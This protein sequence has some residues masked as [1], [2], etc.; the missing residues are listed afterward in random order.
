MAVGS[1]SNRDA[2]D[3]AHSKIITN[4][5]KKWFAWRPVRVNGK[6]QWL[7]DVYRQENPD[8]EH[9][10]DWATYRYGTIFDVIKEIE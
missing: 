1:Y 3:Y 7:K 8:Y 9:I 6:L 5:W 4:M 10:N 2:L